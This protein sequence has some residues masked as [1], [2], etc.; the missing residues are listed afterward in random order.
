LRDRTERM[1]TNTSTVNG[2]T[3]TESQHQQ[4][5]LQQGQEMSSV[6]TMDADLEGQK[7]EQLDADSGDGGEIVKPPSADF[8]D[9]AP[10]RSMEFPDGIISISLLD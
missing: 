4:E 2:V 7:V 9:L 1:D 3:A 8:P 5:K 6:S 10:S